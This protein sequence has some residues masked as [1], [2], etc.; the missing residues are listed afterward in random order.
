[1][2][3][4]KSAKAAVRSPAAL[5]PAVLAKSGVSFDIGMDARVRFEAGGGQE[6]TKRLAPRLAALW[7]AALDLSDEEV[8]ARALAADLRRAK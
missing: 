2:S 4:K 1:V 8:F 5:P 7:N 6:V 3:A